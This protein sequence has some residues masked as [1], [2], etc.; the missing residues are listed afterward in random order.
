MTRHFKL[1]SDATLKQDF[2][3]SVSFAE[4]DMDDLPA[5]ILKEFEDSRIMSE[6]SSRDLYAETEPMGIQRIEDDTVVAPLIADDV[7]STDYDAR[8]NRKR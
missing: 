1:F 5:D 3:D 8:K 2:M 6:L 7:W 4:V